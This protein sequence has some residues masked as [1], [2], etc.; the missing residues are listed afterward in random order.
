MARPYDG[1]KVDIWS[2]GVVLYVLVCG[3]LPFEAVVFNVLRSQVING[4]YK[5]PFFLSEDCTSLINGMLTVD[6]ERRIT[7]V[8][9]INHKWL[10]FDGETTTVGANSNTA[11]NKNNQHHH[12]LLLNTGEQA[13]TNETKV[14]KE[15]RNLID[16]IE[17][18]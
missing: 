9:I 2:L 17:N 7:L 6:P 5:I 16:K 12:A 8:D 18:M 13:S 3:Y 15:F 10:K 11:N 1:P 4:S 14:Y